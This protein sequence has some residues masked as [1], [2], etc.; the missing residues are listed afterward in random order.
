DVKGS[1]VWGD[2]GLGTGDWKQQ[3]RHGVH[4]FRLGTEAVG[5]L[6]PWSPDRFTDIPPPAM[7]ARPS[8]ALS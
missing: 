7:G 5:R 3:S 6:C 2:W 1:G 8:P 4:Q